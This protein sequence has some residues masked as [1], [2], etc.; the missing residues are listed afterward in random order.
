M[1]LTAG[2]VPTS[3]GPTRSSVLYHAC[4]SQD[5]RVT[6]EGQMWTDADRTRSPAWQFVHIHHS[7]LPVWEPASNGTLH[8]AT[9]RGRLIHYETRL[10]TNNTGGLD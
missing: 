6:V 7:S 8:K 5:P 9:I 1:F 3:Q 4:C 2:Y 10:A